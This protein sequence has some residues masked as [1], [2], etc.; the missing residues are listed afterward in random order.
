MSLH[1]QFTNLS[2]PR[3]SHSRCD[4]VPMFHPQLGFPDNHTL[5]KW[6][7]S[8]ARLGHGAGIC[9]TEAR[10]CDHVTHKSLESSSHRH[11]GPV[12]RGPSLVEL[13]QLSAAVRSWQMG[14]KEESRNLEKHEVAVDEDSQIVRHQGSG[15]EPS[16]SAPE[17]PALNRS[18]SSEN[19]ICRS[20][21]TGSSFSLKPLVHFKALPFN[22]STDGAASSQ[23]SAKAPPPAQPP[24]PP[25]PPFLSHAQPVVMLHNKPSVSYG[26]GTPRTS[27]NPDELHQQVKALSALNLG[28]SQATCYSDRH[29]NDATPF[30]QVCA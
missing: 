22:V 5:Q 4:T 27:I 28:R 25:Q 7:E 30:N 11:R 9:A 26:R 8:S 3:H 12:V 19:G 6:L 13:E 18:G 21:N 1:P 24:P 20:T 14:N 17:P 15:L 2:M 23:H 10:G 16:I 29:L